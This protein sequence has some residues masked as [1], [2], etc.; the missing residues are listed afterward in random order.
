VYSDS[1]VQPNRLALEKSPYLLQHAFNPVDWFPWSAE[2]FAKAKEEDKPVFL[3]IGYSTCHWC[4]VMEKESYEDPEVAKL[5]N[6]TFVCIK[7][8]REE[9]P[10]LDAAYMKVCQA[11]TGTGGWPLHVI[12]TPD[13]KPFYAATYIPKENMHGQ[14]GIKQLTN[15]INDLWT[16]RRNYL[17]D[18]AE[19]V[20]NM[21]TEKEEETRQ[22]RLSQE[23][24]EHA[25][26]EAFLELA[27]NYDPRHGGF[28][29][30]PKFPSPQNLTF[31]LRYWNRTGDAEA[32]EMVETTLKW[33]RLGGIYDQLGFGFHRYSTDSRWLVPHFEKMLY[34]QAML[35]MAYA[36]A[37]QATRKEEYKQTACEVITYVLQEMTASQGGFYSAEDADS[38]GEEGKYYL[39][40]EEQ[41]RQLLPET[42]ADIVQ[43]VFNVEKLG[44]YEEVTTGEKNGKNILFLSK[45]LAETAEDLKIPVSDLEKTVDSARQRLLA[46]R[47]KR[48]HP[49]T[50]DKILTDWNG[51]MIAALAESARVFNKPEYAAAA[52]KA[53]GFILGHMLDE[54]GRLYHRYREGNAAITGFLDDYAFLVWG[55]IEL[56]ETVFDAEYLKLAVEFAKRMLQQFWDEE[57]GG[58]F[59]TANNSEVGF[60]KNKD[61][62][63]GAYPSGNS[64]AAFDLLRLARLTDETPFEDPAAKLMH[65]F[66]K[67]VATLPSAHA[68]MMI[69]L[70][71]ALGPSSEV[72][73]VGNPQGEDTARMFE[74]LQRRFI[75]RKVVLFRSSKKG[76]DDITNVAKFTEDL[77][78]KEGKATAY[79]CQNRT[80]NLPTTDPNV[81]LEQL[82]ERKRKSLKKVGGEESRPL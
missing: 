77:A 69:A 5:L 74:A 19:K 16:S 28:G 62:H 39:W 66:S 30:A 24:G 25:L 76:K 59:Q 7:V 55:L 70:D 43:K 3:S 48:V 4:H 20:I 40:T 51:L 68:Q 53:A 50:D 56:Y 80:C 31:L 11:L 61:P 75:P 13:K 21:L 36:E 26:D 46:T 72:V 67:D 27:Q 6:A 23:L 79:V 32:L 81:M 82:D 1:N 78:S 15:R 73:I 44:N 57:G 52:K 47:S 42:E 38:E 41:I 63:D 22:A 2:A 35:L 60:V 58:F 71:F 10:D 29:G 17:L 45:S 54:E 34:D 37:F 8:D 49:S 33:M 12:M 64:A 9:R 18:S 65:A 14:I